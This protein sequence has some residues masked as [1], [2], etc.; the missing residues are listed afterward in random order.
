MKIKFNP[1]FK[2]N[3]ELM[4]YVNRSNRVSVG[5][6]GGYS[7][8]SKNMTQGM[9]NAVS[10]AI[11]VFEANAEPFAGDLE[12]HT[13]PK[14]HCGPFTLC[15][16]DVANVGGHSTGAD[17][18]FLV[19]EGKILSCAHHYEEPLDDEDDEDDEDEID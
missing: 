15:L 3:G 6:N 17:G 8:Y 14:A 2:K 7:P 1:Y 11:K 18:A 16:T 5:L 4:L 13:E 10:A 12:A 19:R 9:R